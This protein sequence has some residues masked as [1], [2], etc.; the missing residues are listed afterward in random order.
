MTPSRITFGYFHP[1]RCHVTGPSVVPDKPCVA[2]VVGVNDDDS[3]N[4]VAWTEF[5]ESFQR[6]NVPTRANADDGVSFFEESK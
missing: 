1:E 4:L 3:V 5:G 2:M 6:L